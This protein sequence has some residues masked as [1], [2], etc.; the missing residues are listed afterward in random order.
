MIYEIINPS[1]KYTI[2]CEDFKTA[3]VATLILG[4]GHWGLESVDAKGVYHKEMP[5]FIFGGHDKWLTEQ[6]GQTFGELLESIGM[7]AIGEALDSVLIGDVKDRQA[8]NDG[9]ALIDDPLKREEWR[10]RW[11]DQRRTSMND[12]GARA[13]AL[14]ERMRQ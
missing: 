11:H 13:Y 2:E 4:E 6:F 3:C 14:A 1:D 8:Y 12:I 7:N 9:L 5:L 10:N